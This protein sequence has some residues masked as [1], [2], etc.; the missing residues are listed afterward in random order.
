MP[1]LGLA[2]SPSS[3]FFCCPPPS[4]VKSSSNMRQICI[5]CPETTKC[6]CKAS[7][8]ILWVI[9][10]K[11][12]EF[13]ITSLMSFPYI[14][15]S[16]INVTWE[17]LTLIINITA[18][19]ETTWCESVQKKTHKR[20]LPHA[21]SVKCDFKLITQRLLQDK[22]DIF[23]LTVCI[24]THTVRLF[25]LTRSKILVRSGTRWVCDG[26]VGGGGGC[27]CVREGGRDDPPWHWPL[28]R[29]PHRCGLSVCVGERVKYKV[30]ERKKRG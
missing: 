2:F 22:D 12:G 15:G 8:V 27:V 21:F 17:K 1:R 10:Q 16:T 5:G 18:V 4:W 3:F 13:W 19:N 20:F 7:K 24:V 14:L 30:T 23:D 6:V 9:F 26:C 28:R 11:G 25:I 29:Q